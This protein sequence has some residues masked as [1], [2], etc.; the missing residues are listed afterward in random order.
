MVAAR[1]SARPATEVELKLEFDPADAARIASHPALEAS[2]APPREQELDLDLFRHARLARFTRR[3]SISAFARAAAATCRPSRPPRAR[4]SFSS[5][6]NGSG[7]LP[8]ARPISTRVEG[9]AL[10]PLLTP[11][12][13]ASLRPMFETRIRRTVYLIGR[14]GSEIEVAID[15]GEIATRTAH[16]RRSRE[17]ELELKRG[18]DGRAVS[19]RPRPWPRRCRSGSR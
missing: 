15:Q 4:P 19:P 14:D 7:R 16:A 3:A 2:L 5:A 12:V 18:R 11:E 9:T 8:A 6:S 13:R 10:E 1:N 17:L